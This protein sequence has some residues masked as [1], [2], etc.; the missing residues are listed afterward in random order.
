MIYSAAMANS[1]EIRNFVGGEWGAL[2]GAEN[3]A[4]INPATGEIVGHT[5]QS[6]GPEV[7]RTVAAAA[8]AYPEWRSTPP[9]ERIQY[10]F[11]LKALLERE[12]QEIGAPSPSRTARSC[13][14]R[15][16]S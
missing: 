16:A 8:A 10:L 4:V 1:Y 2:A 14:S 13:R 6:P 7:D 9:G 3:T 15:W 12:T 11:K 5:P